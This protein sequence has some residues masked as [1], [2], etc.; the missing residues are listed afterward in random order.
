MRLIVVGAMVVAL[1]LP[2][3]ADAQTRSVDG[4][5]RDRRAVAGDRTG[6]MIGGS[7]GRG[8]IAI[9][10]D[11][12]DNV[13]PLTEA[14]SSTVHAGFMLNP[15]LAVIAEHWAITY[16]DRGS[17]WFPDARD[18]HVSQHLQTFGAQLWL[19]RQ[20]YLRAGLGVGWHHSESHYARSGGDRMGDDRPT[21]AAAE[22]GMQ[23]DEQAGKYT[24]AA[25]VGVG[26]EFAHTRRFAVDVQLRAGTTRR[27][28]DEYQV[29]N[30]GLNFGVAWY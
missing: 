21:P 10:C 7:I 28:S 18:H 6:F 30:V 13:E 11:I 9:S 26:F 29:H 23:A 25:T 5:E 8:R 1:G 20:L 27:P 17:D 2:A 4:A 22:A 3:I 12:C 19:H 15:R 24:P 16:N 14:L